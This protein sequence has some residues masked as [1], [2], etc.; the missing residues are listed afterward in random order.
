LNAGGLAVT[1]TPTDRVTETFVKAFPHVYKFDQ[2]LIGSADPIAFDVDAIRARLDATFTQNY[3]AQAGIDVS[4]LVL[5]YLERTIDELQ[6]DRNDFPMY[7]V[8]TDLFPKDEYRREF[9]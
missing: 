6:L 8:N 2:I 7:D 4:K 1:W 9:R 3:F 5:P